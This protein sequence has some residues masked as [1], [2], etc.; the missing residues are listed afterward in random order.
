M[1]WDVSSGI[2][3]DPDAGTPPLKAFLTSCS[4]PGASCGSGML[5]WDWVFFFG[6][7]RE[8]LPQVRFGLRSSR[9][10]QLRP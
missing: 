4:A 1:G 10:L 8:F 3:L 2:I 9:R 6:F 7:N 5:V